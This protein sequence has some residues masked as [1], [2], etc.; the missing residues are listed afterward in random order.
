MLWVIIFLSGIGL[1]IYTKYLSQFYLSAKPI[2]FFNSIG[3][4]LKHNHGIAFS[5]PITGYFQIGLSLSLLAIFIYYLYHH[6]IIQH[7]RLAYW[8]SALIISGAI[9]NL[10]ERI[11]GQGVTDFIQ[12]SPHFPVF[13]LADT[14]VFS[15]VILFGLSEYTKKTIK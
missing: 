2:L 11:Q 15:G 4:I 14:L 6:K 10:I 8:G 7:S 3:F 9:G 13:N 5:L 12:I 1:D